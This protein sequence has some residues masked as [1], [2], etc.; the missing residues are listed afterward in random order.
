MNE[1][2]IA[3][4]KKVAERIWSSLAQ[5]KLSRNWKVKMSFGV[6][7]TT[8]CKECSVICT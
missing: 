3:E 6:R 2:E 8:Q 5:K 1:F 7:T 4:K